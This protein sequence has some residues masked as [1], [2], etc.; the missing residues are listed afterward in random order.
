MGSIKTDNFRSTSQPLSV[1]LTQ[2]A[3]PKKAYMNHPTPPKKAEE[4]PE[5][6]TNYNF[7]LLSS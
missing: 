7:Y 6:T 3:N 5:H 2:A 4:K 1:Q